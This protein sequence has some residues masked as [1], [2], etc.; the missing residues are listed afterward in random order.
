M[1]IEKIET[2]LKADVATAEGAAL[3]EYHQIEAETLTV[4]DKAEHFLI[5][6]LWVGYGIAMAAGF[7]IGRMS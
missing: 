2:S 5:A 3:A 6:H 7:V 4:F 1:T